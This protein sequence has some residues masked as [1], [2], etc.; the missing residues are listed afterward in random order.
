MDENIAAL[1]KVLDPE[2]NSTG[3]GTASAV[4]G[5]MAAALVAMVA[6]LSIGRKGMEADPFYEEIAASAEALSTDLFD[7][8]RRDSVAF[9]AVMA[10]YGLPRGTTEE[11]ASRSEAVQA[12]W[13]E[14]ARVP[15][16]NARRCAQVLELA[17]RLEGHSNLSA[18]SDLEC[19]N[20][21]ARAGLLGCVANVD[22][23]ISEIQDADVAG[24]LAEQTYALRE[25]AT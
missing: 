1:L 20:H 6:R 13:T 22:I 25:L 8:A 11:K 10:A 15:L 2:D 19:A 14:A 18:A 24:E 4:A 23:N 3:G 21:L 9:E 7:G 17:S 16:E 5:S 12:A